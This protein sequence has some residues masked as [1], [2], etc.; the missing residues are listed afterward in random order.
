MIANSLNYVQKIRFFCLFIAWLGAIA[1][2]LFTDQLLQF[3]DIGAIA[4]AGF[5]ILTVLRLRRDSLLVLLM[6]TVVA[7]SLI[8][9]W[10]DQQ[11]WAAGGRYIL[12]FG[13]FL[14]TMVMVRATTLTMVSVH[15]TQTALSKLPAEAASGGFQLA[16]NMFGGVINF[17]RILLFF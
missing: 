13:A 17:W 6:L 4:F 12:I 2:V 15:H 1:Q 10:P 7:C 9:Q 14:P 3:V 11:D 8:D 5:I 16:A